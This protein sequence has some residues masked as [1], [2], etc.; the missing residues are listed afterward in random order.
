MSQLKKTIKLSLCFALI[1]GIFFNLPGQTEIESNKKNLKTQWS[2]KLDTE[3]SDNVFKMSE[4]QM[5]KFNEDKGDDTIGKY[6]DMESISDLIFSIEPKFKMEA[7][8]GLFSRKSSLTGKLKYQYYSKN[9]K[10]SF[11]KLSLSG[12]QKV[13]K[14]GTIII[15]AKYI[16][17]SF[18]KNYQL[19][20]PTAPDSLR[21]NES[22]YSKIDLS[23]A[24]RHRFNVGSL[25]INSDFFMGYGNKSYNEEFPGRNQDAFY[26]GVALKLKPS[27][28]WDL[29]L[30]Y[31]YESVKSPIEEE[32]VKSIDQVTTVNRSH[33]SNNLEFVFS[34]MP[35]KRLE[36]Y[37]GAELTFKD[38]LSSEPIDPNKKNRDDSRTEFMLGFEYKILKQLFLMV[39]YKNTNQQTNRPEDPDYVGEKTDY[40][41]KIVKAGIQWRF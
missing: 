27:K 3:W 36:I 18:K 26:T 1:L 14:K 32:P 22:V 12:K 41:T 21:Y 38:Y 13:S 5:D 30:E 19:V 34:V 6:N 8:N 10:K 2:L 23:G 20:D 37:A 9:T 28:L 33:N 24:Y 25:K 17:S 11:F 16:P 7:K 40:I 39:E 31:T 15:K 35:L 29:Y 4:K